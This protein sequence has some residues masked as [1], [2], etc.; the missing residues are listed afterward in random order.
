MVIQFLV[1]RGKTEIYF[2]FR[3]SLKHQGGQALHELHMNEYSI[4]EILRLHLESSG[5]FRSD[6]VIVLS[7]TYVV[8]LAVK[9]TFF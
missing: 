7:C 4:T 3:W 2:V 5:A 1:L 9:T 8:L 6:K